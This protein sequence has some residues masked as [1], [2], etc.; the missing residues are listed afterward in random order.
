MGKRNRQNDLFSLSAVDNAMTYNRYF[1]RLS[2]LAISRFK[3]NN[4]PSTVDERFL[5]LML[6]AQGHSIFFKDDVMGYLS[7]QGAI[8]GKFNVYRIPTDRRAIADNGYQK[9]LTEKD[10][11]IIY[12]N[13]LHT[14]TSVMIE[15]FARR[16][17]NLDR[18]IDVNIN[19]QKTP[20]MIICDENERLSLEN[21]Y[22]K[23]DGNQPFIFGDK[24][25]N[26]KNV[27]V[28]KTDAPYNADRI[29]E[30]KTQIWN[31][32]LTY[33]GISNINIIKKERLISDEVTRNNAG[34][35][36]SRHSPLEARRQACQLINE[37]FGL[38]IS[39]DYRDDYQI[40]EQYKETPTESEV[41]DY[42]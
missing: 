12:D 36:A 38:D 34:T 4:L 23:Y 22:M 5:E 27:Q 29:Y 24:S 18:I 13:Y 16:L 31:E 35:I 10:S 41:V 14:N 7:L 11:V 33:L 26:T 21:L 6:F 3:W 1:L 40:I 8:G 30:L 20:V 37:M 39:V 32:A 42:E 2:E 15:Q 17:A 28:L 25:I 9:K 19:A